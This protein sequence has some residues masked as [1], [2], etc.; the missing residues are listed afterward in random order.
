MSATRFL[1]DLFESGR[2]SVEPGPLA[3]LDREVD[4]ILE[5]AEK[6]AAI[7]LAGTAPAFC[8]STAR[9]AALLLYRASQI[10]VCRD[11]EAKT[12]RE[13]LGEKCPQSHSPQTDYSADLLFQYLPDAIGTARA[14]A[15]GDPLLQPLLILA[16]E[17]PLSSVGVADAGPVDVKAFISHPGMRQL[18]ADRII[19][20]AD[21]TRLGDP[22]VDSAVR[23]ALGAFPEL[24]KP[25]AAHFSRSGSGQEL[26]P[27][28]D[29]D[30]HG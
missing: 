17:W 13:L 28:M 10:V 19:A 5:S 3:E 7:N 18:Y 20:R 22:L 12:I 25:I 24:C 2:V 30:E 8:L 11:V 16:R 29:T 27:Q 23:E 21:V 14:V 1:T 4:P 6:I 26:Q 15:S 9:W